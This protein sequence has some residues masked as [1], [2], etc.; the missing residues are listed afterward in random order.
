M[1]MSSHDQIQ[2]TL[3]ATDS[4]SYDVQEASTVT[5][6]TQACLSLMKKALVVHILMRSCTDFGRW[7]DEPANVIILLG[8]IG[9]GKSSLLEYLTGTHGHSMEA[10]ESGMEALR[11]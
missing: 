11:P 2:R 1:G 10:T 4:T 7:K 3:K 9:A 6:R 5:E 8:E